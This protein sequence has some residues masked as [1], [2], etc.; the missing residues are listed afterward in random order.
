MPDLTV[1]TYLLLFLTGLCSGL[2]DSIA[3]GGLIALPVLFS[4]GLPPGMA[5]DTNKLQS[6]FGTFA[7]SYNYIKKGAR[8][9]RP[10][11][12]TVVFLYPYQTGL[13]DLF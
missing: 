6:S 13:S 10:T 7:A 11:F 4:I 1:Q 3:G 12:L 5:L 8:F 2:V 9:I